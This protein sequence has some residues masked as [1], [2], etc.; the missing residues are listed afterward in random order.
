MNLYEKIKNKEEKISLVGLGYVGMPIAV[1][2]A[3]KTEVIGFDISKEKIELYTGLAPSIKSG[4]T[5]I[6]HREGH[7]TIQ[8]DSQ[9]ESVSEV[10]AQVSKNTAVRDISV[11]GISAEEMVAGLYTEYRI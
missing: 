8:F 4:W 9:K 7:I 1:A 6:T 2:F 10:I 3:K 5:V 11:N